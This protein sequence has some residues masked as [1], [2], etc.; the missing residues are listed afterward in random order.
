MLEEEDNM[1]GLTMVLLAILIGGW[2]GYYIY[3]DESKSIK[4]NKRV[5]DSS[6]EIFRAFELW[7]EKEEYDEAFKILLKYAKKK[8]A[9]AQYYLAEM[10]LDKEFPRKNDKKALF[11]VKKSAK[12]GNDEALALLSKLEAKK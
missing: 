9:L 1:V 8:E 12:Q 7:Q 5:V 10:Y 3:R 11:W 2:L 4:K 6:I